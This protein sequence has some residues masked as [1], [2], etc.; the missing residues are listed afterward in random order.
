MRIR[1]YDVYE[2]SGRL[3]VARSRAAALLD[4]AGLV[5]LFLL[6][7]PGLAWALSLVH[8]GM[9]TGGRLRFLLAVLAAAAA[10]LF[11]FLVL[12]R[13][14]RASRLR[15]LLVLDRASDA[16]TR[17]DRRL[18]A[19]GDL[20]GVELRRRP[21]RTGEAPWFHVGLVVAGAP[22]AEP[23]IPVGE[24]QGEAEMRACAARIAAYA[25]VPVSERGW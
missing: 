1:R 12:L 20:A 5:A 2:P 21:G 24:S 14:Y 19:L 9:S 10:A 6:G 15:E 18:C 4:V 17:G 25:G 3:I 8:G 13:A 16:V 23:A 22:S 7:A 11:A